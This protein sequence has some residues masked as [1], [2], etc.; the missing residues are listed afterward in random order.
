MQ[1]TLKIFKSLRSALNFDAHAK[2]V[3]EHEP[4]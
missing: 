2:A 4:G 1:R 3:I